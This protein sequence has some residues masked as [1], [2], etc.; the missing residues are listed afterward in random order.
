MK[1]MQQMEIQAGPFAVSKWHRRRDCTDLM[2][3]QPGDPAHC[4]RE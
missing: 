1:P 4:P 2:S 3:V